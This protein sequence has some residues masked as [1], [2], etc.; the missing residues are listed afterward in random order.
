M[1]YGESHYLVLELG[2]WSLKAN[3]ASYLDEPVIVYCVYCSSPK[4]HSSVA[5]ETKSMK[6]MS[7]MNKEVVPF[8]TELFAI[9]R[10]SRI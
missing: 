1:A 9:G 6:D 7:Q 8:K 5:S 3:V 10:V 2:A 4:R